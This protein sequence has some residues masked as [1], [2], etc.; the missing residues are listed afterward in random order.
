MGACV[1]MWCT[2]PTVPGTATPCI[3]AI[4]CA[5]PLCAPPSPTTPCMGLP[6]LGGR[7]PSSNCPNVATRLCATAM[8]APTPK[9]RWG[10]YTIFAGG[11]M[12][13][14]PSR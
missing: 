9:P 14:N 12:P 4:A 7:A 10:R 6:P 2:T 1:A 3:A 8:P 13:G 5:P 11:A